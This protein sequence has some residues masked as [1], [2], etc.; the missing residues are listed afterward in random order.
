MFRVTAPRDGSVDSLSVA[1]LRLHSH[2]REANRLRVRFTLVR[3]VCCRGPVFRKPVPVSYITVLA[4]LFKVKIHITPL[5]P[6]SKSVTSWR[7]QIKS[8]LSVVSFLKFHYDDLL[9]TS[10]QLPGLRRSYGETCLM[11]FGHY[12]ARSIRRHNFCSAST[13]TYN[14]TGNSKVLQEIKDISQFLPNI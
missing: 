9:P 2:S 13:A 6:Y 1:T 11:D 3:V 8:V 7:G 10:W 4:Y 12:T 5:F 14:I